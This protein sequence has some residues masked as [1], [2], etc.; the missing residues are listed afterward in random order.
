MEKSLK[1][2]TTNI[3]KGKNSMDS[4]TIGDKNE[5]AIEYSFIDDTITEI[6]MFHNEQNILEFERNGEKLTT[7]WNLDEIVLWLRNFI[8]NMTE[9]P[10]PVETTGRFAAQKDQTAREFE[11][12]NEEEFDTYYDRLDEWNLRH[13]WH[14][15]SLGAIISDLYFQQVGNNVEISWN[16][17]DSENDVYFTS[18]EGGFVIDKSDFI[19]VV[20]SFLKAYADK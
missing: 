4:I 12:D 8:N 3:G 5:F 9:D 10:Y 17:A 16:N 18:I 20:D 14:T 11:S 7:R 19:N 2:I 1:L 13:R 6:A 15:A